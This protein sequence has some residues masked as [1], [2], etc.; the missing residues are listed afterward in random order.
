M[1]SKLLATGIAVVIALGMAGAAMA[2]PIVLNFEGLKDQEQILNFYNGG[3]GSLGSSGPNFGV[4]FQPNALAL[5]ATSAG[6]NGNFQG[7][8]SPPTVAFFLTGTADVMNV[9]AGFTT[10]FSFFYSAINAPGSVDVFAGLNGT[11]ALLAH[12]ALPTTPAGPYGTPACPIPQPTNEVFCPW[13]PIGVAFAG[14]AMS[15]DFAGTANQI[16]FDNITIGSQ[17]PGGVPEPASLALLGAGLLGLALARRR[18]RD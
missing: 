13:V 9:A 2:A 16:G 3:T 8:P 17:T 1:K 11:G 14:T 18:R 4:A 7:E 6:G 5:I 15:V 12:L 10:G